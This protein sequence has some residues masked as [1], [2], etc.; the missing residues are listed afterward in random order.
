MKKLWWLFAVAAGTVALAGC[1]GGN[2]TGGGAAKFA[3]RE[4]RCIAEET[5]LM[6]LERHAIEANNA[7]E[8][9]PVGEGHVEEVPDDLKGAAE[10]GCAKLR[11]GEEGKTTKAEDEESIAALERMC[12][13]PGTAGKPHACEYFW[14]EE[15]R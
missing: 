12:G 3:H 14:E 7:L 13:P 2:S 5:K 9:G 6:E 10:E 15:A 8:E 1:G 11:K 4:A